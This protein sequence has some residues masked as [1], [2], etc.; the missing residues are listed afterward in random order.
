M[1]NPNGL[2]SRMESIIATVLPR[3]AVTVAERSS[4][5]PP[6]IDLS[7]AENWL[8]RRELLGICKEAFAQDVNVE[9]I[10]H[11]SLVHIF[12]LMA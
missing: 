9:V 5:G 12:V 10:S 6:K 1:T 11:P 4:A 7:T 2:S 3:I 8:V